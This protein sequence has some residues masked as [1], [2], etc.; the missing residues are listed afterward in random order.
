MPSIAVAGSLS[1]VGVPVCLCRWV[2]WFFTGVRLSGIAWRLFRWGYGVAA[3]CGMYRHFCLP[4]RPSRSVIDG[5]GLG[6]KAVVF[7]GRSCRKTWGQ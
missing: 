4:L 5:H 6:V 2:V 7:V 3:D 1:L